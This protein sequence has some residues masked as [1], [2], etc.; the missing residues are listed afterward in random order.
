MQKRQKDKGG[1][2]VWIVGAGPGDLGLVTESAMRCIRFAD[3]IIYDNL[4]NP[5]LL[6]RAKLDAELIY[7][8]K[9][10]SCHSMKQEEIHAVLLKKAREGKEVLRLKGGDPY[11]FGRGAEEAEFL[12]ERGIEFEIISGVTSAISVPAG[13]GIPLTHRDLASSC[14]II[15]GHR[16]K[17]RKPDFRSIAKLKGT[18]VFL[19]GAGNLE[20]IAESLIE[21]GRNPREKVCIISK[22]STKE[23]ERYQGTL[24]NI[25]KRAKKDKI[26]SPALIVVGDTVGLSSKLDR[27]S[28][29]RKRGRLF[30]SHILLTGTRHII[31]VLRP[32]I[33][34]EG[35][36]V[37]EISLIET[38][39]LPRKEY[40]EKLDR[41]EDYSWIVFTS[42]K[43]VETFF[44]FS[45]KNEKDIDLRRF[46]HIRFA[47]I[48]E[49]TAK[50]LRRYGFYAD[51]IPSEYCVRRLALELSDI[52]KKG[53]RVMILRASE[54][55]DELGEIF[56]E[57][58]I[59]YIDIK[60]YNTLI[61]YR[62]KEELN[63][64]LFDCDYIF[65]CS[66]LGAKA[67]CE[68]TKNRS[69]LKGKLV[70]IGPCTSA[71]CRK[72]DIIPLITAGK[73]S[74]SGMVSD[75]LK[76]VF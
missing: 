8:G 23:E 45:N 63:R 57:K 52:V 68:M 5:S 12:A 29:T 67:L 20:Y 27:F 51:F 10:A 62:R 76:A 41:I 1:G 21:Y 33:E 22:G 15:T 6:N 59:D 74:A 56:N 26:A 38:L 11:I 25:A 64:I 44:D 71:E 39:S 34:E 17:E 32:L 60:V 53:E 3:V 2:K 35:A 46:A 58:R 70:S 13:A 7:A 14:H 19:M 47:V 73:Y 48:G 24:N 61:D 18:L 28:K 9:K 54:G 72:H 55:S 31:S 75:F 69:D 4:I 36:R 49:G 66:R 50:T 42:S 40:M 37:T 16:A 65:V 30:G 43:G